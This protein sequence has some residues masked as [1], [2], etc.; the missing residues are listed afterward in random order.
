MLVIITKLKLRMV[1]M[2]LKRS[3]YCSVLFDLVETKGEMVD[4][5]I[6]KKYDSSGIVCLKSV[7]ECRFERIGQMPKTFW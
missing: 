2:N 1:M 7:E 3:H 6:E 4:A 5:K